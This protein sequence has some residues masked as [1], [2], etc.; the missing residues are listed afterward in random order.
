MNQLKEELQIINSVTPQDIA[1]AD[2]TG[3]YVPVAGATRILFVLSTASITATK[4]ATMKLVQA[5]DSTG[6]DSKDLIGVVEAVSPTGDGVLQIEIEIM[7]DDLDTNNGFA[8]VA[9]IVGTD[10]TSKNGSVVAIR[11]GLRYSR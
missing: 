8:F 2:I 5:K 9:P 6:L 10:D 4:K 11:G 7:G 3:T 1:T